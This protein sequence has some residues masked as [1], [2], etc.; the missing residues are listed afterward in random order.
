MVD[1]ARR[2]E[3]LKA[4]SDSWG[5]PTYAWNL[6][7]RL[8]KLAEL[9]YPGI[10][11]VAN[12]GEGVSYLEFAEAALEAVGITDAYIESV[13]T[14]SLKRPATRPRNSRLKCLTSVK[15]G[16]PPLPFW[17]ESLREFA[18][19]TEPAMLTSEAVTRQ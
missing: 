5:T 16:L 14:D 8:R 12:A 11:H 9:K 1:R 6:A 2:G 15:L 13:A 4:I 18:S 10:F 17:K 3:Q 7:A 19:L